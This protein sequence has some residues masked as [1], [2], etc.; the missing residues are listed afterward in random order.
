MQ[1]IDEILNIENEHSVSSEETLRQLNTGMTGLSEREA[2]E[3]LAQFGPNELKEKR[4]VSPLKLFF[5]QFNNFLNYI[6]IAV[7]AVSIFMGEWLDSAVIAAI[8]TLNAI[9]GFIQEFRAEKSIEALKKLSG[10]KARVIRDDHVKEIPARG[11]V[12]GDIILVDVG[13]KIPADARLLEEMNLET[14]ES[15]LTGESASVSKTTDSLLPDTILAERKNM[16][17]SGTIVTAGRGKAVVTKTGMSTHI[18]E[19]AELIQGIEVEQTPLQK[20]LDVLAVWL[21]WITVLICVV[22]SAVGILRGGKMLEM[23]MVGASLAVAAIPEGLLAVVTLGLAMGVQRMAKRHALTRKLPLVET[24]GCATVICSDKTGTLTCNEMTVRKIYCNDRTIEVT[25]SGYASN[26]EFLLEGKPV[27]RS[28]IEF[29]LKIG[30]LNNNSILEN[31][32]LIGEPT[33]GALLVSAR[34]SGLDDTEIKKFNPRIG[35]IGFDSIRKMMTTIH[36]NVVAEFP[37]RRVC[38]GHDTLQKSRVSSTTTIAKKLVFTKGAVEIVLEKCKFIFKNG[39]KREMTEDDYE[40]ILEKNLEFAS[41]ALRVLA[42]AYKEL[43]EPSSCSC[44]IHQASGSINRA[45]TIRRGEGMGE[46]GIESNLIFVGMQA[47]IDPPRPE[48][49]EAIKKCRQAGIKVVMITGDFL[50]TAQAVAR[51]IGLEGKSLTGSDIESGVN[52]D[53]IVEDVS[54]YA[55]VN[56]EHKIRIIEA[57]KKKGHVV[58]MTGDGVNDAPALKRADIGIAMGVVGTDV[59]RESAGM[60]LT[61]DN[62]ASIVNAVEEGRTI[63]DNI[64]KFVNYLLSGNLGEVLVLFIAMIIGFR[65]RFGEIIVPLTAI[66]ILWMNLVT[67]GLPALALSLDPSEK[68]IMIRPPRKANEKIVSKNMSLNIFATGILICIGALSLFRY[69]LKFT[70][71]NEARTMVFTGLV[72]FEIIRLTMIRS[73]YKTRVFSNMYLILAVVSSI[74]LQLLVVYIPALNKIFKTV[75][76]GLWEWAQI[77]IVGIILYIGDIIITAL[78]RKYT[79]ERD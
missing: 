1:N 25:G 71:L 53:E 12:P 19:I 63:Y 2:A 4:K 31:G 52:L 17:F 33:E 45:T 18:G 15:A 49:A 50:S 8:L 38:L 65:N 22:V 56:P 16:L 30:V 76:L 26:G 73:Q 37:P 62:F 27:D 46:E 61:D 29:L 28:E 10:L 60:I 77:I 68:D 34:K 64:K 24:L 47:M 13:E 51:E 74:T 20:K 35:E 48:A 78:I 75:P 57:F 72:V 43:E 5:T 79:L 11:L 69:G 23:I 67:D 40:N 58:A 32:K 44:L 6:L 7:V 39:E 21:G 70:G 54:V 42:F 9:L 66:Q 55:R 59:A 3:R 36:E 41:S 14:Q